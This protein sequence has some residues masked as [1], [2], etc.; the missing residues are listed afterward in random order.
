MKLHRLCRHLVIPPLRRPP[1]VSS[2]PRR[3][4]LGIDP[5][6]TNRCCS[7]SHH[8]IIG[9]CHSSMA[10]SVPRFWAILA[11]SQGRT[12]RRAG[13]LC[14]EDRKR[15]QLYLPTA[16]HQP[17]S[18]SSEKPARPIERVLRAGRGYFL[19]TTGVGESAWPRAAP[20][21]E[22]GR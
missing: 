12:E 10:S 8:N 9:S 11:S 5:G 7:Y 2:A 17:I 6:L 22:A 3:S 15:D 20:A 4:R 16:D 18:D 14:S 21:L 1:P 19:E 13:S